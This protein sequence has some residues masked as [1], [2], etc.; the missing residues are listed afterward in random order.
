MK[1][2]VTILTVGMMVAMT[3]C[4][5]QEEVKPK[6][7]QKIEQETVKEETIK[8]INYDWSDSEL[9]KT[10]PLPDTDKTFIEEDRD[11]LFWVNINGD[12]EAFKS[13]VGKCKE[14]GFTIDISEIEDE[15]YAAYNKDG[16]HISL[17]LDGTQYELTLKASK[18]K[19]SI[20]WPSAGMS[21]LIPKPES[22]IGTVS[23]DSTNQ[24]AAY[25]G[26]T[27]EDQ[28]KAYVEECIANGFEYDYTKSDTYFS[29]KNRN[30]DGLYLSYEGVNTMHINLMSMELVDDNWTPPAE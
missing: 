4:S 20:T 13:Y 7:E 30:G 3:G 22:T 28:F 29:G 10:I 15:A 23:V 2:L 24:F 12:E 1:K 21:K 5:T 8:E 9:A 14:K 19:D 27:T 6:T 17:W 26:D 18:I 16:D 11:D 25:I